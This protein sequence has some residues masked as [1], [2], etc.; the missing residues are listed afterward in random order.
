MRS[1]VAAAIFAGAFLVAPALRADDWFGVDK[2]RSP[3][4]SPSDV[5]QEF[6]LRRAAVE[7]MYPYDICQFIQPIEPPVLISL[8]SFPSA[9]RNGLAAADYGGLTVYP[10]TCIQV[11]GL[12]S[13]V[14][15]NAIGSVFATETY[16]DSGY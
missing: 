16:S 13:I 15:I 8:D 9:F 5:A 12:N 14:F 4:A 1:I 10:V 11:R 2:Q 3:L 6:L 7:P